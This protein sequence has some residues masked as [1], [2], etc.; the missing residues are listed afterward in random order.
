MATSFHAGRYSQT[1]RYAVPYNGEEVYL[2]WANR[3]QYYV[4]SGEYFS[5]YR[6]KSQDITVNFDLRDVDV[7]KDN[8]Q[9]AK[10]FFIPISAETDYKP[11]RMRFAFPLNTVLLLMQKRNGGVV[12]INKTKLLMMPNRRSLHA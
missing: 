12:I 8:I 2:H 11:D 1:D 5:S 7:E 6:F 3:D 4:K 9:G 10:R